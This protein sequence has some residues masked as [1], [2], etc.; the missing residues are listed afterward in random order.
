MQ[1]AA[2]HGLC[3]VACTA[4]RGVQRGV[5]RGSGQVDVELYSHLQQSGLDFIQFAFRWMN[6]LLMR[7]P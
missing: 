5:A 2:W 1:R 4:Q 3:N 7:A 6:C